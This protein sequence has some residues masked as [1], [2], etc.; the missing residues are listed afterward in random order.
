MIRRLICAAIV[1][2]AAVVRAQQ[3]ELPSPEEMRALAER[4][5]STADPENRFRLQIVAGRYDEA[6]QSLR[7]SRSAANIRWEIY[8]SA[9][10]LERDG[11]PF[12]DAFRQ[13]FR[14]VMRGLDD[15]TAYR[16]SWSLGTSPIALQNAFRNA[17][18]PIERLRA[19]L[20][21]D[22]YTR[23]APLTPALIE[24]DDARR[25]VIEKE[26]LVDKIC[27]IIVRPRG[28]GRRP[29]L[30]NFS[31]Y[32]DPGLKLDE[33]R[34]NA[35]NGYAAVM[36]FTRGK[37]CSPGTAVT[38]EHDG[39]DAAALID[40]IA[41][42]PWSDGRVGMYGGSYEGG[43][44]WGAAKRMP[45]ALK[46]IMTGAPVAPGLD[47]P[48]EGNVFWNFVYPFPFYTTNNKTLD[49]ATYGDSARW[50]RMEA[51]WYRTGRAYRDLEKIDG[52]PNP[53][54][55]KWIAHPSYDAYW[56]AMIPQG[57]EYAR[58]G[59]PVLTTA[60]YYYG[61]PGAAVHYFSEHTRHRPNAEHYLLIG[62][63]DHVRGHSGTISVL[64]TKTTTRIAGYEIEPAAHIDMGELRYRWFDYVFGR[65]PKPEILRDKVNYEVMGANAWKHAPSIGKMA[66]SKLRIPV[67]R[68]VLTVDL[69]DR[70][71]AGRE[72]PGGSVI[73]KVI[74]TA[75]AVKIVSDPIGKPAEIA[76]LFSGRLDFITN[77]RDFDFQVTLYELTP[78][79]EVV[80]LAPYWSR[81][82]TNGH[83]A[84]RR[85]LKPGKRQRLD[86]TS[87]RLIGRR[88]QA[89]S[90]IVAVIG[91][92]KEPGRQINYGSGKD[93]SAETIADAGK[94]LRIEW[95]GGYIDVPV[96]HF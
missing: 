28:E 88:M 8:A 83:P 6:L 74:D 41:A 19:F 56:R 89:G 40:W 44:A 22:A 58:I 94:P 63:Y 45:K 26:R 57:E 69:A 46:G 7:A 29:A 1:C 71:D 25:Y 67:A 78:S 10:R 76:G 5:M 82:S 32:A 9:K 43:T 4:E 39:A 38:Y 79:G 96:T 24:E 47:V 15:A 34:R 59:I 35:S 3:I 75:N 87:I 64:G 2:A 86:F 54:F 85:L 21:V 31:I 42:Q 84:E 92:I 52:T 30:L 93:V 70:S 12:D 61:G 11:T 14:E 51:E 66:A 95:L 81:A 60:G 37:A 90:R 72:V 27:A 33:A 48:M 91:V 49:N 65:G 13:S 62:P 16:V 55:A 20:G 77:K 53:G 68:Q 18:T 23:F 80:L 50:Q 73:D 36:G 17:K